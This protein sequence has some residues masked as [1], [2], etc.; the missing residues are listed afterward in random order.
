MLNNA[1]FSDFHSL[2]A[3]YQRTLTRGVQAL[4]SYTFAKSP[5][6]ASNKSNTHLI[7]KI[8]N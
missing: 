7:A 2:Q 4:A 6:N 1:A 5:D 3:Q 8:I